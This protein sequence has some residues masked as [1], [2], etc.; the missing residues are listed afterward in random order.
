MPPVDS[1]RA[2]TESYIGPP[3]GKAATMREMSLKE[4]DEAL[5]NFDTA[6]ETH[7]ERQ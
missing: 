7:R 1:G 5:K 6:F 2:R 3:L 4:E